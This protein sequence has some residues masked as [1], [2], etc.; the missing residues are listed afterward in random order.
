M[1]IFQISSSRCNTKLNFPIEAPIELPVY[2]TNN[3]A[4]VGLVKDCHTGNVY[5]D[6]LCLFRCL[7]LS[8]GECERSLERTTEALFERWL[9]ETSQTREDFCGV[10]INELSK[11]EE[12]FSESI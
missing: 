7:A 2:I 12:L 10:G 5:E 8:Q 3:E 6:N 4:M 11:V 1:G 9:Q